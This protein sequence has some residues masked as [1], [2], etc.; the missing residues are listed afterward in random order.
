MAS[1]SSL[2]QEFLD[3]VSAVVKARGDGR[4]NDAQANYMIRRMAALMARA[5]VGAMANRVAERLSES[6][7]ADARIG[8][9]FNSA[10]K[11]YNAR[12]D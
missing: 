1:D 3:A 10:L 9:W 4:L 7:F 5:K 8:E 12:E 11:S 6:E 2:N